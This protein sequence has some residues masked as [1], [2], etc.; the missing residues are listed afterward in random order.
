MAVEGSLDTFKLTEIL[1]I[2]SHHQKT[3]ILTVQG[4]TNI[5]AVS[6]LRGQVVAADALNQ[7]VEEGLG[8]VLVR[9]G[10][11]ARPAYE[12]VA[13]RHQAGAGRLIDLLV[14][15]GGLTR[16]G[17]LAALRLQTR[18]L[19]LGL[20]TWKS[21]EFK[22][23]SGDEVFFEEGFDPITVDEL[24]VCA[25][26]ARGDDRLPV[27]ATVYQ[28]VE[29]PG[30]DIRDRLGDPRPDEEGTGVL[31]LTPEER[32]VW[33]LLD[34]GQTVAS[35]AAGSRLGSWKVRYTL[36]RLEMAGA[37]RQLTAEIAAEEA[38]AALRPM[39][40]PAAAR[41][42]PAAARP[43]PA[44]ADPPPRPAPPATP[45]PP[46]AAPLAPRRPAPA[47]ASP[48]P[49]AAAAAARP[50]RVGAVLGLGLA[51]AIVVVA[52]LAP[53][54]L[55]LPFPWQEAARADWRAA[56]TAAQ[57]LKIERAARTYFLHEGRFP[58]ELDALV[59]LGLLASADLAGPDGVPLAYRAEVDGY[60]LGESGAT[61]AVTGDFL[62]D[63]EFRR[64][65]EAGQAPPLVL[66]D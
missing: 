1:R 58:Q 44:S 43:A 47:P 11:I 64:S 25:L 42:A 23:Y 38:A 24:L 34:E 37:L 15:F 41:P 21:G 52:A 16:E 57:E 33:D 2:V 28:R 62:L 45:P 14:D 39:A 46:A 49:R 59:T 54:R 56:L 26:R 12:A 3:G 5:V 9:E 8:G 50:D 35:L 61:E 51:G 17:V 7:T 32:Q 40:S 6:F 22:F 60:Q 30:L 10:Q 27:D 36:Y 31:W 65:P 13:G 55:L 53:G 48:R 29:P 20:F 63:P 19:V 66:L 4:E 18:E